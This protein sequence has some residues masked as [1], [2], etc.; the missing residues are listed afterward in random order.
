MKNT[1]CDKET[2]VARALAAGSLAGPIAGPIEDALQKHADS[3]PVC[4]EVLLVGRALA[5]GMER[6]FV[7]NQSG[8]AALHLPDAGAV[9]WKAQLIAKRRA[10][11]RAT[12]AVRIVDRLAYFGGAATMTWLVAEGSKA[13][14]L[15]SSAAPW[16]A[17]FA[18]LLSGNLGAVALSS[19][20]L[21]M[22]TILLG[23]AYLL[24]SEN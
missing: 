14:P 5:S 9:W 20:V 24:W 8:D 6:P 10:V 21:A 16:M 2:L 22:L 18:H 4:S 11:E 17:P 23:S 19:A 15:N 7:E 3:C 1:Y 12:R 13:G